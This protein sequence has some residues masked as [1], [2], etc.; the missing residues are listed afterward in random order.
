MLSATEPDRSVCTS[1]DRL[2]MSTHV[3]ETNAVVHLFIIYFKFSL[4][5]VSTL[6]ELQQSHFL[7]LPSFLW[8]LFGCLSQIHVFLEAW[9][10]RLGIIHELASG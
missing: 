1:T 5:A 8:L 9:N 10:L 4:G 6:P 2:E 7:D 3:N